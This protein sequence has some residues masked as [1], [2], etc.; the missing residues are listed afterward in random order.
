M[1]FIE[2]TGSYR[3]EDRTLT[4]SINPKEV[5]FFADYGNIT[6]ITF[7]G[8][9]TFFAYEDYATVKTLLEGATE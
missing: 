6:E 8:D 3:G 9:K 7:T 5:K 1:K 4:A 2:L